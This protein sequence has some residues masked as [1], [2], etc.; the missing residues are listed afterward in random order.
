MDAVP[1]P[2]LGP[3]DHQA[4]I[5]LARR[6]EELEGQRLGSIGQTD[7]HPSAQRGQC[8]CRRP[9]AQ[10]ASES[11]GPSLERPFAREGQRHAFERSATVTKA[12]DP[13]RKVDRKG[14]PD[15]RYRQLV[16]PENAELE[17]PVELQPKPPLG[18]R[19][20][21]RRARAGP[22]PRYPGAEG[23]GRAALVGSEHPLPPIIRARRA[24]RPVPC[25]I[26]VT[27]AVSPHE[28]GSHQ[29]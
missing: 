3:P 16:D 1:R 15:Q 18:N 28:S 17:R 9:L 25:D 8:D 22:L 12:G 7:Q 27:V 13:T 23:A 26:P 14:E 6:P 2:R 4:R 11:R 29:D 20:T 19:K 10:D 24:H 5:L 21:E